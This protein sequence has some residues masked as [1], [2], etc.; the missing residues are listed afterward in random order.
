VAREPAEYVEIAARLAADTDRLA[1]LRFGLRER[2]LRSPLTD[3]AGTA[4]ALENAFREMWTSW[5]RARA[6][7]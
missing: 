7:R 4:R 3:G 6:G 1:G 5:C 2:M